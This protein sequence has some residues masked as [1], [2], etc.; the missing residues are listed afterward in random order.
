MRTST[1]F[2]SSLLEPLH[3]LWRYRSL[4]IQLVRRD[5][6]GRYRGSLLGLVWSLFNPLFSLAVYTF[7]FGVVFKAKWPG[8][9]TDNL[10]EFS[11]MLFAGLIVFAVFSECIT[12]A[13]GIVLANPNF[14]KKVIFPLEILPVVVLGSALFQAAAS[15]V[16]LLLGVALVYGTISWTFILF[17]LVLAPLALLCLGL[18]WTLASLGVFIRDIGQ[19]V[20]IVVSALLFLSPIFFPLS[21]LPARIQPWIALNP[22]SFPVEQARDV[23]V[24]GSMPNWGGLL[25]Y[26]FATLVF[27]G[28]GYWWFERTKRGFADVI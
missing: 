23:L 28:F 3:L 6:I 27:A 4:I 11:V 15:L 13:P 24:G 2:Q 20:G 26:T 5:V 22:L 17:P 25:I 10:L 21:A 19:A 9:R 1:T 8:A 7:A 12:R 18:G 16:I 14:V